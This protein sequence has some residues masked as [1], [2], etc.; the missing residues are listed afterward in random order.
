MSDQESKSFN[1]H[2]T[3]N[4]CK[5]EI[6]NN[7]SKILTIVI[8]GSTKTAEIMRMGNPPFCNDCLSDL[9]GGALRMQI[10][11]L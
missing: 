8:V 10:K 2:A 4:S 3:C 7:S 6:P 5:V 9:E 1:I 11:N